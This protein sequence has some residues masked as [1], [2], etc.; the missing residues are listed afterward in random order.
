MAGGAEGEEAAAIDSPRSALARF[1]ELTTKREFD[2]AARFLDLPPQDSG[3]GPELARR[4][5]AVLIRHIAFDLSEVSALPTGDVHDGLSVGLEQVGAIPNEDGTSDGVRM[6]RRGDHA[7]RW[8]FQRSTVTRVDGWYAR[9]EH[10]EL[11]ERAPSWLLRPGPRGLPLWQWLAIIG[12]FA[13]S[14]LV[15]FLLGL[16]LIA[17]LRPVA[18]R[19]PTAW[20]NVL[21]ERM[22]APLALALTLACVTLLAGPFGL[23]RAAQEFVFD[24][25]RGG[26]LAVFFLALARAV[27]VGAELLTSSAWARTHASAYSLIPLGARVAKLFVLSL[28]AVT[29]LSVLGYPVASLLAGLGIGGLAIALAAQKT[30][31]NLFGAF[32]LGADQPFRVGDVVRIEEILGTVEAIGLRSTRIRTLDRTLVTIPNGKLAEMRLESLSARDRMR[33]VCVLRLDYDTTAPQLERIVAGIAGVLQEHPHVLQDTVAVFFKELGE[34]ALL[35]DV[36]AY[37]RTSVFAE[38]QAFRQQALMR[39]MAVVEAEGSKFASSTRPILLAAE[40]RDDDDNRP[41]RPR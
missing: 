41:A 37:F 5:R 29:L 14:L 31:E 15:G 30:V 16:G 21:L 11:L 17:I 33:F 9:L 1:L 39:F 12:L 2:Q 24:L 23:Q 18:R 4:L 32:S 3:R 35:V 10:R 19:T 7:E 22:R 27:D 36:S 8:L 25:Q 6:V 13:A 40:D 38:F 26:L 28:A 20:D 34:S